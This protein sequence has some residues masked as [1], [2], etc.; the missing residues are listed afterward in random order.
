MQ[1][2]GIQSS[3]TCSSALSGNAVSCT[4]NTGTKIITASSLF[5]GAAQSTQFSFQINNVM[6]PPTSNS[7]DKLTI[8]TTTGSDNLDVCSVYVLNLQP[9]VMQTVTISATS[10]QINTIANLWF[11]LTVADTI[12]N[13]ANSFSVE[14]PT[15][16][17]LSNPFRVSSAYGNLN[18]IVSGTTASFSLS[19]PYVVT[20]GNIISFNL[21][22]Y[23]IP[24]STLPV[25]IKI[26]ILSSSSIVQTYAAT[27]TPTPSALTFTVS[28]LPKVVNINST[29]TFVVT[30]SDTISNTG[31]IRITFPNTIIVSVPSDCLTITG[32]NTQPG[33]VCTVVSAQ[34]VS[35]TGF[36]SGTITKNTQLTLAVKGIINPPSAA[37]TQAFTLS[38]Y[39]TSSSSAL[40]STGTMGSIIADPNNLNSLD[41]TVTPSSYVVK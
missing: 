18:A 10:L 23:T 4:G 13:S 27:I 21:N 8:T 26:N 29:Y 7:N 17:I 35:F 3:M 38:T 41:V 1:P 12:T 24:T 25:P 9:K 16:S 28:N 34:T 39:Y 19:T 5:V 6:S 30:L 36:A 32:T 20:V 15:G 11:S 14:F 37:P 31:M 40:V 2:F 33:G 22:S